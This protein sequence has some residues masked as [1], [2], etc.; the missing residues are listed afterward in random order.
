L[1]RFRKQCIATL[2]ASGGRSAEASRYTE[3]EIAV[4]LPTAGVG[5]PEGLPYASQVPSGLRLRLEWRFVGARSV[6]RR[7]RDVEQSQVHRQLTPV[8]VA[9]V[10]HD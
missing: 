9:V 6:D 3:A 8:M 1:G 4:G 10:E 2:Y 7:D 5:R